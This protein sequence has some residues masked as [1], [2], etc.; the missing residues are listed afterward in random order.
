MATTSEEIQGQATDPREQYLEALDRE[1][2]TT[3]RVLRSFPPDQLDL[4]PSP[5]S[6]TARELA[7]IF[8]QERGLGLRVMT[9]GLDMS[10]GAPPPIPET[11]DE[12]IVRTEEANRRLV[13][14]IRSLPQDKLFAPV[15][16]F[17][18]PR[19]LG[20]IPL[21]QFAWFLL[22]DEIHHRGQFSVYVRIAGGK[23]PSIYGP[24]ADEPWF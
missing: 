4:R 22:S 2:A 1:F 17:V 21:L 19:T 10:G 11:M 7:W 8:A 23:L 9:T 6:K 15:K 18:A 3:L 13:E 24:T 12:I 14:H 16:F 5:R 20:D